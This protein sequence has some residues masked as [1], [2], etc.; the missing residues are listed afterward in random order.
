MDDDM[1]E[2]ELEEDEEYVDENEDDWMDCDVNGSEAFEPVAAAGKT[3]QCLSPD[4]LSSKEASMVKEVRELLLISENAIRILLR[5]YKWNKDKLQEDYFDGAGLCGKLLVWSGDELSYQMVPLTQK[6]PCEIC[7]CT[8]DSC[9]PQLRKCG[10]HFCLN[11]YGQYVAHQVSDEGMSSLLMSC[12]Y[13]KCQA[14]CD[15]S[16]IYYT[17]Q[18]AT[19]SSPFDNRNESLLKQ[20]QSYEFRSIVE[21]NPS[22]RWCPKGGCENAIFMTSGCDDAVDS[23]MTVTCDCGNRFCFNCL[24][25][26]HSPATCEMLKMWLRKEK[27]E[28]ETANWITANTKPCPGC[29]ANIEKNAGCNHITCKRCGYDFCWVC[30]QK[31]SQ[32]GMNWYNCNFYDENANSDQDKRDTAKQELNRYIFYYTRYHN[33]DQSKHLETRI[34]ERARK[35]MTQLLETN[36]KL[37]QVEY[38]SEAAQQLIRSRETLKYTY[39]YAYSLR[40]SSEK[41]LFEYNQAQLELSTEVLSKMLDRK[42]DRQDIVN[43][44]V[45][46]RQSLEKLQQ[47]V[48]D[49]KSMAGRL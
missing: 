44:Q 1:D 21:K 35:K 23:Q 22:M 34:L 38:L 46:V 6:N 29:K 24:E 40:D 5:E 43:Q 13:S 17:L 32:H 42:H 37:H 11:C 47:G 20:Y 27:D 36:E 18:N 31:W 49:A 8:E 28:S 16:I 33:H 3:Y 39:I 26:G 9:G 25:E 45:L 19:L 10:H 14:I 15:A 7:Y 4:A 41:S 12:P 30:E 2:Y 48:F